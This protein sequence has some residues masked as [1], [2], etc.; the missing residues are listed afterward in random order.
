MIRG[1]YTSALGM[2]SQMKKMDIVTNN[3][4]NADTTGFK[5]D[6]AATQSFSAELMKRLD[7]Q[8][9]YFNV[10]AKNAGNVSLGVFVDDITTDFSTG[11][12]RQTDS[13]LDLAISGDAF[14]AISYPNKNGEN[15]VKYTRDGS[16]TISA[17]GTIVTRDG[18]ALLGA[19][20][21]SIRVTGG[22][23]VVS[24]NG[25]VYVNDE[26]LGQI[27]LVSFENTESLRKFGSNLYDVTDITAQKASTS[28][29]LQ[30]YLENSNI[31]S[32]VEMVELINLSRAYEANQ[33][34]V[35]IH[36]TTM[37]HLAE[38]GRKV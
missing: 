1:L 7:D 3:I 35:T 32:V 9:R 28:A 14:F 2:T 26:V 11:S 18:Y 27:S 24:E 12:L 21:N 37:G 17:D 15:S 38:I 29:L 8:T 34:M 30:G 16:F 20:G 23:P 4:A 13:P 19:D 25:T 33:K 5:R 6:V 31:N 36:D 22:T 10:H